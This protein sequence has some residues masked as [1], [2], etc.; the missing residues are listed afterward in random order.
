MNRL[1]RAYSLVP[2]ANCKG[3]CRESCGPV[4]ASLEERQ[5][6]MERHRLELGFDPKTLTCHLLFNGKCTVYE[7]RPL[8]CRL[9]GVAEKM[10]CT[11][12]CDAPVMPRKD[13]KKAMELVYGRNL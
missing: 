12:G 6:I 9:W 8:L 10:P 3:L 2:S 7:D 11:F 13:E 1:D 5:R 4:L